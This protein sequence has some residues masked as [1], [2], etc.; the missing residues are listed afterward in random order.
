MFEKL[1]EEVKK[2]KILQ[3]S[4]IEK[5]INLGYTIVGGNLGDFDLD[6]LDEA[7]RLFMEGDTDEAI[8]YLENRGIEL[9]GWRNE[10]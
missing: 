2:P 3:R 4:I 7:Y 8:L 1:F 9:K 6:E 10:G 5:L